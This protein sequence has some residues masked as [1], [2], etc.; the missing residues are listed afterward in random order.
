M[1]RWLWPI[2]AAFTFAVS[3]SAMRFDRIQ[4]AAGDKKNWSVLGIDLGLSATS[5]FFPLAVP[6]VAAGFIASAALLWLVARHSTATQPLLLRLPPVGPA[7]GPGKS[8]RTADRAVR[9]VV[10]VATLGL[11]AYSLVHLARHWLKQSVFQHSTDAL[12]H[13]P[14]LLAHLSHW[15]LGSDYRYGSP[16]GCTYYPGFQPALYTLLILAAFA[17]ALLWLAALAFPA[18]PRTR[19]QRAGR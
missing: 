11:S 9:L 7:A 13:G 15:S 8:Q 12:I 10:V 17:L 16:T 2:L 1:I 5:D 4:H 6:M 18:P 3:F 14:G 19:S